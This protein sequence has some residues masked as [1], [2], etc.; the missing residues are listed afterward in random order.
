MSELL[1]RDV[2]GLLTV[3]RGRLLSELRLSVEGGRLTHESRRRCELNRIL[4]LLW[5]SVTLRWSTV[6]GG[7]L[8]KL[9][10]LRAAI[11]ISLLVLWCLLTLPEVLLRRVS[12]ATIE[13]G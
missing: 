8:R 12:R 3:E 2:S 7:R 10:L 11:I 9:L 13:S 5:C 4:L 1:L 6:L